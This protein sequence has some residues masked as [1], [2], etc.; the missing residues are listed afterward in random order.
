[1]GVDA[2]S[3]PQ[4]KTRPAIKR[5][6]NQEIQDPYGN[7]TESLQMLSVGAH[8][9]LCITSV[10]NNPPESVKTI[11]SCV[12]PGL[13]NL[14]HSNLR[15][16]KLKLWP[17]LAARTVIGTRASARFSVNLQGDVEAA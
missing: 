6:L 13:G 11:V 4:F 1:V 5:V 2:R 14:H 15:A 16:V 8:C 10:Q 12:A 17:F 7:W 9:F 3:K